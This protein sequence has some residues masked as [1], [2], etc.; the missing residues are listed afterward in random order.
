MAVV[1]ILLLLIGRLALLRVYILLLSHG[2]R[3]VQQQGE[4]N[5]QE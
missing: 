3:N 1:F 5:D 2:G 4:A